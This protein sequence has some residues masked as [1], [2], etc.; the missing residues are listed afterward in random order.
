MRG[1]RNGCGSAARRGPGRRPGWP[2][3]RSGAPSGSS[4]GQAPQVFEDD[5]V[6]RL[7]PVH[8]HFEVLVPSPRAET[9]G[10][11]VRVAEPLEPLLEFRA[12]AVVDRDPLLP[13]RLAEDRLV[14]AVDAPQLVD[15]ALVVV[16]AQVDD[17]VREPQVAAVALDDE[18]A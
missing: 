1:R 16:H 8:T 18:Q 12:E 2:R 9:R 7:Y 5:G 17:H 3:G 4:R 13:G 10:E 14:Q 6:D 11:A 15:R